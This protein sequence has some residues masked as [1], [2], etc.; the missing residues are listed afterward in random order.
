MRKPFIIAIGAVAALSIPVIAIQAAGHRGEG[1]KMGMGM[2]QSGPTTRADVE[3][4]VKSHFG[5]VDANKDGFIVASEAEDMRVKHRAEMRDAHF[6]AMDSNKDGAISR[7]EF[8]A[9][10]QG[11]KAEADTGEM[12]GGHH[13]RGGKRGGKMGGMMGE[14]MFERADANADGK[15][16]L[17]EAL[18]KP[19]ARFD[20]A[21]SNKDGTLTPEE[22]KAA[23]ETMRAKWRDRRG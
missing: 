18:A 8:D 23:R 16:S 10:H 14:R 19:L 12:R 21:D 4:R 15:V 9:G 22:R 7:A 13:G 11:T 1:H 3:A 20:A 5:A 2:K 6:T 17:A